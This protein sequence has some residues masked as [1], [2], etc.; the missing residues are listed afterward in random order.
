[1]TRDVHSSGES[2]VCIVPPAETP[3]SLP[4][5]E[6]LPTTHLTVDDEEIDV[7]TDLQGDSWM[8][9]NTSLWIPSFDSAV[10]IATG[11]EDLAERMKHDFPTLSLPAILMR[12]ARAAIPD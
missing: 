5:P 2:N 9:S 6:Q 12:A 4:T 3:D 11:S 1:M 10:D 7:V 8:P